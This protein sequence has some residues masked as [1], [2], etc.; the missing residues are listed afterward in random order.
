MQN[1]VVTFGRP[2]IGYIWSK[3]I[4]CEAKEWSTQFI[5]TIYEYVI[6]VYK[7][8]AFLLKSTTMLNLMQSV[9]LTLK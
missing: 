7:D 8:T 5:H 4:F 1:A 9:S 2:E 6:Q 3:N